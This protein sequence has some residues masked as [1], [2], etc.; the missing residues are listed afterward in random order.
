MAQM[1]LGCSRDFS[2]FRVFTQ[3]R[4]TSEVARK[5]PYVRLDRRSGLITDKAGRQR[6]A[7]KRHSNSGTSS[8]IVNRSALKAVLM[9]HLQLINSLVAMGKEFIC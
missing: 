7:N 2:I 3:P 6:W 4:S 5:L 8:A 9:A 1:G